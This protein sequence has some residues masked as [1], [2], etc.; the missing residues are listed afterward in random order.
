MESS[1]TVKRFTDSQLSGDWEDFNALCK[2]DFTL[3]GPAPKP[4]DKQAFLTWVKSVYHG[5]TK[6]NNNVE[7]IESSG[8]TVKCNVQME[9]IHSNDWDL[10]FMGLGIIPATNKAWK[11]P[12]EEMIVTLRDGKVANIKVSVPEDGGIPG[13]MSQLGVQMPG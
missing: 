5:N 7:I 8:D 4:L 9:G 1:L 13:I 12:K 10:S 6:I 2:D 3:I 11:N